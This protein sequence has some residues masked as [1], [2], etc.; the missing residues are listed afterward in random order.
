MGTRRF[1]WLLF[2]GWMWGMGLQEI[3][4]GAEHSN[5]ESATDRHAPEREG[6]AQEAK[7][8]ASTLGP[9][10]K[11]SEQDATKLEPDTARE[12]RAGESGDKVAVIIK[13]AEEGYVP[14]GVKVRAQ[15]D[16]K[17][18]TAEIE[19][20]DME[21]VQ[22]DPRVVSIGTPKPLRPLKR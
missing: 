17:M 4:M 21:R 13:V 20:G 11:S 5:C 10:R 14:P 18:F 19:R 16:P 6:G 3:V 15:I 2:W 1:I 9:F 7:P 22:S 12:A 8:R